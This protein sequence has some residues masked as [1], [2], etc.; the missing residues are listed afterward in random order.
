[1]VLSAELSSWQNDSVEE[2]KTASN[3]PHGFFQDLSSGEKRL[4]GLSVANKA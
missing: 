1:M 2:Q 3:E 4:A